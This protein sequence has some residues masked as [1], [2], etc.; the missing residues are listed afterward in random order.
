MLPFNLD[1]AVFYLL[2]HAK[3]LAHPVLE[4]TGV[5]AVH[6]TLINNRE[7]NLVPVG[8]RQVARKA[9]HT[10]YASCLGLHIVSSERVIHAVTQRSVHARLRQ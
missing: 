5:L 3:G 8:G 1:E 10:G 7:A 6:D 4:C 9:E 2:W